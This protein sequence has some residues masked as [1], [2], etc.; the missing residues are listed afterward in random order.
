M[1][2]KLGKL[3]SI[4]TLSFNTNPTTNHYKTVTLTLTLTLYNKLFGQV[5]QF[6][7]V[8]EQT[9]LNFSPSTMVTGSL[10]L[11]SGNI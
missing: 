1:N 10:N 5:K 9:E 7:A 4:R 3:T 6:L 8:I 2:I 11:Y